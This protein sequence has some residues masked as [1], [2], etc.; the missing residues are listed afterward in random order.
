V[1]VVALNWKWLFIYPDYGVASVNRLRLPVHTPV[2][3][4]LTAESMMNSFFVPQLGSQVYAMAGMQTKLHLLA[5]E[6]GTYLGESAAYSGAGFSDMH[7]DTVV[8]S[9]EEFDAWV[10]STRAQA[11]ALTG[12]VYRELAKPS[13]KEPPADYADVAAGLFDGIVNQYMA[14]SCGPGGAPLSLAVK[15]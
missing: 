9:R 10:G 12:D 15:E 1:Q 2:A 7:F 4:D 14:D 13:V 11:R 8:T 6:S 5:N 3:F